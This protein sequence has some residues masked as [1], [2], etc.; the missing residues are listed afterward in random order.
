MLKL[1]VVAGP[2]QCLFRQLNE[3][4][5]TRY[6]RGLKQVDDVASLTLCHNQGFLGSQLF[7]WSVRDLSSQK[8]SGSE[9]NWGLEVFNQLLVPEEVLIVWVFVKVK[10]WPEV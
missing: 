3:R 8:G 5:T 6:S 2:G 10:F 1:F 9:I 7:S 4:F